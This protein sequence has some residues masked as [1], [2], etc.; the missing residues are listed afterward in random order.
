VVSNSGVLDDMND[1]IGL[2][3]P[4]VTSAIRASRFTA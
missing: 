1:F 2:P 3:V 4:K